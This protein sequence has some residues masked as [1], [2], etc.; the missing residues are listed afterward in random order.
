MTFV[1]GL[2]AQV[3]E[4]TCW[5]KG[6]M[7]SRSRFFHAVVSS[8]V[9]LL[10]TTGCHPAMSTQPDSTSTL[11]VASNEFP[12]KFVDH[13]FGTYCYNTLACK[14]IYNNYDFNLLNA[15][16]PSGPPPSVNYKEDWW[17]AS[18][19]GIRNFPPPAEVRWTSLDG[20]TH[21]AR[22]DMA[23][24]FKSGRVLY[25]VPDPEIL[26]GIFPQGLVAGPSIFLEVNDRTI[27]IYMA[28]LIPTTDEQIPGNKNSRARTDLILAWTH[29]Y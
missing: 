20:A 25:K 12:L 15:D 19:G 28:A 21:E 24:I 4:R 16:K 29:T 10:L 18:H 1:H 2:T 5:L 14:V 22:V 6:A 23:I 27:N 9:L 13:S 8:V 3:N 7:S 11:H 26:D 17:P